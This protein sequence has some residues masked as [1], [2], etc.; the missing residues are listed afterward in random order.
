[1]AGRVEMTVDLT[2]NVPH[3]VPPPLFL[4]FYKRIRIYFKTASGDVIGSRLQR[5]ATISNRMRR[6]GKK[7]GKFN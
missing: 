1:M 2:P 4:P 6:F 3:S 5:S 7:N